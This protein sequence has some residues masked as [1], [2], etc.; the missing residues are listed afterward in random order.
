M[1]KDYASLIARF[2]P[3]PIHDGVGYENTCEVADAFAGYEGQMTADQEDY[4]DLLCTL[5]ERYDEEHVK[6]PKVTGLA[7]LKHLLKNHDMTGAD[8]SR[9]L[10][11]SGK[12]GGMILRGERSITAEHARTLSKH[13]GVNPGVFIE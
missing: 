6:W 4:Y 11:S 3:R 13:F 5:I 8:L 9:V 2:M 7:M 10:G 1:P 12:L